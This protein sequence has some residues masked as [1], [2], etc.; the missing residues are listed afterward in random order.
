VKALAQLLRIRQWV[1]NGFVLAPVFFGAELL[2][3]DRL[4]HAAAAFLFFCLAAGM[5]YIINDWQDIEADRAHAEKRNRPLASGV[6]SGRGAFIVLATLVALAIALMLIVPLPRDFFI[7][8]AIYLAINLAYSLGLKQVA[9]LELFLVASGFVLRLL[10]GALAIE[11]RL[12]QWILIATAMIAFVL[13]VGK[14]RDDLAQE[15]DA[16]HHRKSLAHYSIGYL[17]L[18]LAALTGGTLVVYLL[19]C[20]SDYAIDRFGPLVLVTALPVAF[21][22]LRYL[23]LVTVRG[24][25]ASPT[26]LVLEDRGLI[27]TVGIFIAMFAALIY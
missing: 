25:G 4:I 6:I 18:V 7:V 23:Q 26:D 19:F 9:L 27:A 13:T 17:D 20:A 16:G 24:K 3:R 21:G 12:T 15:Y 1:K 11:I 5:V 14:R 22:L 8:V 10:A 2:N